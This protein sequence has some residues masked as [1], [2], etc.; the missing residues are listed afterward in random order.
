[1][2][3]KQKEP[4]D[5]ADKKML[6]PP[7]PEGYAPRTE[8]EFTAEDLSIDPESKFR[9]DEAQ[10]LRQEINKLYQILHQ[11]GLEVGLPSQ[12]LSDITDILSNVQQM[13][14]LLGSDIVR[15]KENEEEDA[16]SKLFN[17]GDVEVAYMKQRE[18]I[19]RY[20]KELIILSSWLYIIINNMRILQ[21]RMIGKDLP[22][23]EQ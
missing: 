9:H 23:V 5:A 7:M 18:V 19:H 3:K 4:I 16:I 14:S 13:Q 21:N 11:K 17:R 22:M 12:I 1:M 20:K 10:E 8:P 15:Q 6:P 2:I